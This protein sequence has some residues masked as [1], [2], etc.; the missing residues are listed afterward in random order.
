ML[1]LVAISTA[2]ALALVHLV[3]AAPAT[4]KRQSYHCPRTFIPYKPYNIYGTRPSL[5]SSKEGV[6]I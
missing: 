5:P 1:K 6:H 4:D 3:G 2:L